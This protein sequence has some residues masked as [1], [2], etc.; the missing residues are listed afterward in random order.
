MG[1]LTVS[2]PLW[3]VVKSI[4]SILAINSTDNVLRKKDEIEI[5]KDIIIIFIFLFIYSIILVE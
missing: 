1:N 2:I 5:N 3:Y 4:Y